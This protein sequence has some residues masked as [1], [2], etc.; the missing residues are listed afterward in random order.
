MAAVV[1]S[2]ASLELVLQTPDE[3]LAGVE[4]LGHRHGQGEGRYG[5]ALDPFRAYLY[6]PQLSECIPAKNCGKNASRTP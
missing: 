4:S 3:V 2:T 1:I 5:M 6:F